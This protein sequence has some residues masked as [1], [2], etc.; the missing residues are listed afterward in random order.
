MTR[1]RM[2]ENPTVRSLAESLQEIWD[3]PDRD[4]QLTCTAVI[5]TDEGR[6][7]MRPRTYVVRAEAGE[8]QADATG[9]RLDVRDG[10][11]PW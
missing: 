3:D 8:G 9:P 5:R 10:V 7:G 11:L 4:A 1:L 6:D 2:H